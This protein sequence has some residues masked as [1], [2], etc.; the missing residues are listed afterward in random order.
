ML[1]DTVVAADCCLHSLKCSQNL[2]ISES[3]LSRRI[4]VPKIQFIPKQ[5]YGYVSLPGLRATF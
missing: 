3:Y 1:L 4:Y 5:L 2:P